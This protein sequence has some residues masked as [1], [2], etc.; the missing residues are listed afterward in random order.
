[1]VC[2][3]ASWQGCPLPAPRPGHAALTLKPARQ[4]DP[5]GC[6]ARWQRTRRRSPAPTRARRP[7]VRGCP[8]SS[9]RPSSSAESR[10]FGTTLGAVMWRVA[11]AFNDSVKR[12]VFDV[13]YKKAALV[14]ARAACNPRARPAC[15]HAL[16]NRSA[17]LLLALAGQEHRHL[18]VDAGSRADTGAQGSTPD[19]P[20]HPPPHPN[21]HPSDAHVARFLGGSRSDDRDTLACHVCI[22]RVG[23][24]GWRHNCNLL[25]CVL[26]KTR[27]VPT[28]F[29][30]ASN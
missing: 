11:A 22:H 8:S 27:A 24:G 17:A 21:A 2:A 16:A 5:R 6:P 15:V 28:R 26:P 9:T 10:A 18:A 30:A 25:I 12:M 3:P 20:P 19:A 29:D 7:R 23:T 1:M 14:R 4:T 13:C